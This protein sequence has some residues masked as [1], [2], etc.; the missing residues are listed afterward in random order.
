MPPLCD[1]H[2]TEISWNLFLDVELC[3]STI[4]YL[5]TNLIIYIRLSNSYIIAGLKELE[6]FGVDGDVILDLFGFFINYH[7]KG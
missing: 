3:E 5:A 2:N 7:Y 6:A 4:R 1:P